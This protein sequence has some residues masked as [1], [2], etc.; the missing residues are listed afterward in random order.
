MSLAECPDIL[1]KKGIYIPL[2][3]C[4]LEWFLVSRTDE[5]GLHPVPAGE[6]RTIDYDVRSLGALRRETQ[7]ELG[8]KEIYGENPQD[9]LFAWLHIIMKVKVTTCH[10]NPKIDKGGC[11]T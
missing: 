1:N 8:Q 7:E 5:E 9:A 2:S 10:P 11:V 3:A 4:R 6:E